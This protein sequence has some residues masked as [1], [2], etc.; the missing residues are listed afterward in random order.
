MTCYCVR[1]LPVYIKL[2]SEIVIILCMY[3]YMCIENVRNVCIQ[4]LTLFLTLGMLGKN[5]SRR[6]FEIF[7]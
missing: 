7:F 6:H 5:Y 1:D 2:D 4:C 3:V